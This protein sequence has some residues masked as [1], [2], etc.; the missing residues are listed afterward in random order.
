MK[1][2]DFLVKEFGL[3]PNATEAAVYAKAAA[4]MSEGKITSVKFTELTAPEASDDPV[5]A[6]LTGFDRILEKRLGQQAPAAPATDAAQVAAQPAK[7]LTA[8]ELDA[9]VNRRVEKAMNERFA[10]YRDTSSD[11]VVPEMVFAPAAKAAQAGTKAGQVNVKRASEWYDDSKS[12]L[13]LKRFENGNLIEYGAEFESRPVTKN[14]QRDR[15]MAGAWLRHKLFN[16]ARMTGATEISDHDKDLYRE[17]VEKGLWSGQYGGHEYKAGRLSQAHQKT[18]L[19]D[20]TSG[21]S[22]L[23]PYVFD[24]DI[25]TLLLLTN[26]LFPLVDTRELS[27]GSQVV[28]GVLHHMTVASGPAEGGSPSIAV[29]NTANLVTNL[30]TNIHAVTGSV[31]VGRDFLA[32]SP[33]DVVP[34]LMADYQRELGVW[35][36]R[37]IAVGGGDSA[38]EPLGITGTSGI[39][40]YLSVYQSAGPWTA[41]DTEQ[42]ILALPKAYRDT[43]RGKVAFFCADGLYY[44]IR[45]IQV[46]GTDQRRIYGYDYASY[47][48]GQFPVKIQ[49]N[50]G[51]AVLGFANL[52]F[53]RMWRRQGIEFDMT[54]RGISLMQDNKAYIVVRSRWGGQLTTAE[55]GVV[56]NDAAHS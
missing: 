38:Q 13:V 50:I 45:G 30:T 40:N 1:L 23:V 54:D 16:I 25:V 32:D 14:S 29:Q 11:P 56:C 10:P 47:E 46:S 8:E 28:G 27:R 31:L 12:Q 48:L 37:V 34:M 41:K 42:M 15:A 33:V 44:R 3:D 43:E 6:L 49:N 4:L 7:T 24:S 9:E 5:A 18:L 36:D 26:Q 21:G 51:P 39:T 19:N 22:S 52:G 2:K 20:A 17:L 35:L 55:A 53:Y